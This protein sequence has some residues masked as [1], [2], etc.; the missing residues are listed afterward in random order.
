MSAKRSTGAPRKRFRCEALH[1]L[2]HQLLLGPVAA[3]RQQAERAERLHDEITPEAGYPLAYL[4]YRITGTRSEAER[5]EGDQLLMGDAVQPDLRWLIDALTRSAPL[6]RDDGSGPPDT[7]ASLAERLGVSSKTVHRWRERGLR[8]RWAGSRNRPQLVFPAE[9]VERFRRQR[10]D[11]L[12]RARRFAPLSRATRNRMLARAR[13]IA[14]ARAVTPNRVAT[15]LARKHGCAPE[16]V[17]QLLLQHDRDHPENPIFADRTGPLTPR[18][19]RVIERAHAR[20]IPVQRIAR[21]FKRTRSTIYRALHEQ[22]AARIRRRPLGYHEP[23]DAPTGRRASDRDPEETKRPPRVDD[24]PENLRALYGRAAVDAATQ[25]RWLLRYNA[26]KRA[27]ARK[28]ASL[29]RY[30]PRAGDLDEIAARIAEADR[31]RAE[32]FHANL[33][34][35]LAVARGHLMAVDPTPAQLLELLEM[36]HEVLADCLER[37]DPHQNQSFPQY[38]RWALMR[39]FARHDPPEARPRAHARRT[40]AHV[41]AH[42]RRLVAR[43]GAQIGSGKPRA[44]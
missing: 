13:R 44:G 26:C 4:V 30:D 21:R 16:T 19:K 23:S 2:T 34:L 11:H 31:V 14:E 8:W 32:L 38:L 27:A 7:V 1:S 17:R 33:P 20:G 18:Q 41:L 36:G 10:S 28:R 5:E 22:R 35:V 29:D 37:Y 3:R 24:L 15:H 25:R 43:A 42:M 6:P 12:E 9:S 40:G 39:R